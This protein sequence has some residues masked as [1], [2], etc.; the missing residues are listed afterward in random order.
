MTSTQILRPYWAGNDRHRR[1]HLAVSLGRGNAFKVHTLVLEAFECP[2]P[3]G[4]LGLHQDGR[5]DNN[6]LSNL[7][8]GTYED[9]LRDAVKHGVH[10]WANKTKC[11]QDHE[12]NEENTRMYHGRRYCKA[13]G[14]ER[15]ARARE[16]KRALALCQTEGCQNLK[17]PGD[18]L[19]Y[20]DSCRDVARERKRVAAA[21][22]SRRWYA[23]HK[24]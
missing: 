2:R 20:C 24:K 21:E 11:P 12:Y 14:L 4:K 5:P 1:G 17:S 19:R 22:R 23:E 16:A 13:C 8:W 6:R 15:G 10:H 7:Y 9:N 18:R 3:P